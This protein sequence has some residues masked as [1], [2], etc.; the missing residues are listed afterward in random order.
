MPGQ[1]TWTDAWIFIGVISALQVAMFL[2]LTKVYLVMLPEGECCPMCD[3]ATH[4]V[5]PKW[6]RRVLGGRVRHSFCLECGW[7][8]MHR[9]TDAWMTEYRAQSLWHKAFGP[10]QPAASMAKRRSQSGQLPLNSKKSS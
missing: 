1:W 6:W 7:E 10:R 4:A 9:R 3:G 8:G 2:L 5:Q